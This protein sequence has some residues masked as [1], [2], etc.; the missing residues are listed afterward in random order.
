M[1]ILFI[2]TIAGS[3]W[4]GSE[5]LW[6]NMAEH[7]LDNGH[8][9]VASIYDWGALP[10]KVEELK[11]KGLLVHKR[12]RTHYTRITDKIK[13]KIKEKT[14]SEFEFRNLLNIKPDVVF[15]SQGAAFDLGQPLFSNYI[16]KL[17][18]PYFTYLSLNTEYEV[19][20]YDSIVRQKKKYLKMQRLLFSFPKEIWRQL[21]DSYVLNYQ[22]P[23]LLIIL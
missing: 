4:G 3:P 6:S 12:S 16:S 22:T 20:S 5:I 2:T 17:R 1:K 11:A 21:N 7:Y 15:F 13:G 8:Q 9:V 14:V 19:L 23:L 18:V 10:A